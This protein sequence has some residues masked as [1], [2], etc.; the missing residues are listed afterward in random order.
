MI[1][2]CGPL[3]VKA[4]KEI[5]WRSVAESWSDE[6]GWREQMPIVAP[7]RKSEDMQEGLRAFAEKREP[8][9]KGR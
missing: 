8:V 5:A 3:A 7:V 2:R 6:D 4:A 1:A 9:W